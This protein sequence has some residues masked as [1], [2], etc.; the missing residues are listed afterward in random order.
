VRTAFLLGVNLAVGAGVLGWVLY[1]FGAL[2]VALLMGGPHLG[3]LAGVVAW[4]AIAFLGYALRWRM[5]LAGLGRDVPLGRLV[6]FRTAG[7]SVSAVVPSAKLGGEPVRAWLLARSGVPASAAIASVSVDRTLDIAAG[8]PFAC[9]YAALLVRP[10]VPELTG[11]LATVSL[12]AAGLAVGIAVAVRRLRSGGGLVTAMVRSAGLHR[13]SSV[14]GQMDVLA[15]AEAAAGRLVAQPWVIARAFVVGVAVNL[16]VMLEYR[17]LLSAFGLPAGPIAVVAAIFATGAAHSFPVP[18]AVGALEGAQMWLFGMLGHPPAVGLAVGLAVR[19]REL[20][21]I[22]PGLL[23]M[24]GRAVSD[25]IGR[26]AQT[27]AAKKAG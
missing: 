24:P 8:A 16:G 21:W 17:L 15:D 14:Q 7:H 20:L 9:L 5:L 25:A 23:Y 6:A 1:R 2:A 19:L 10:G 18:A 4:V 12:S 27:A 22:L 11:A 3:L 13:L 26:R